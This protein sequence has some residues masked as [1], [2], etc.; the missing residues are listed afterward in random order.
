MKTK[1]I[2]AGITAIVIA[3]I[4]LLDLRAI[5]ARVAPRLVALDM[6]K[7][8]PHCLGEWPDG[9]PDCLCSQQVVSSFPK[10]VFLKYD[11]SDDPTWGG[12]GSAHRLRFKLF[13]TERR[14]TYL[15]SCRTLTYWRKVESCSVGELS[16]FGS[17]KVNSRDG[18]NKDNAFGPEETVRG[19]VQRAAQYH[20]KAERKALQS[21]SEMLTMPRGEEVPEGGETYVRVRVDTQDAT[22]PPQVMLNLCGL[23]ASEFPEGATVMIRF[24]PDKKGSGAVGALNGAYDVR[25]NERCS[26]LVAVE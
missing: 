18:E 1:L 10:G 25:S 14:K 21:T 6:K 15:V 16:I 7:E 12:G 26:Q 9:S 24:R 13:D 4:F 20:D 11:N 2:M 19:L 8:V 23:H 17:E 5:V 3:F 22:V